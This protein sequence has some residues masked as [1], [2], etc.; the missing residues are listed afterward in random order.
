MDNCPLTNDW[1]FR[2]ARPIQ[3]V[4]KTPKVAVPAPVGVRAAVADDLGGVLRSG[5]ARWFAERYH[6]YRHR[7]AH[8]G[9]GRAGAQSDS[10]RWRADLPTNRA[11]PSAICCLAAVPVSGAGR[12][13]ALHCATAT[14]S[15][16]LNFSRHA[17]R[18]ILP[19]CHRL[20]QDNHVVHLG[21]VVAPDRG[22]DRVQVG[23]GH[24]VSLN[25]VDHHKSFG[26]EW[27]S[28]LSGRSCSSSSPSGQKWNATLSPWRSACRCSRS[29]K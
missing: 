23:L 14:S 2:R 4:R 24:P 13:G 8:R 1:S 26:G 10:R 9:P 15:P 5:A 12:C 17:A 22:Q 18:W 19:E 3:T 25:L 6:R 20:D 28:G 7:A 21:P 29:T 16:A 27:I 11:R